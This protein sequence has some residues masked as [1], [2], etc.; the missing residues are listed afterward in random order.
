MFFRSKQAEPGH[1]SELNDVIRG[2]VPDADDATL[3]IVVAV[4]GLFGCISYA[5]SDF[6]EAE[7]D[8]VQRLLQS[9]HGIGPREARAIVTALHDNIV[10]IATVEAAR[11]YRALKEFGDR[12]L[13]VRVLEMLLEVAATDDSIEHSEVQFLRQATQSL[14]LEQ[15]DYNALQSK[16]K[17]KLAALKA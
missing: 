4:A 1:E 14:G 12:D 9:I 2:A 13:R 15:S 5:D 8:A 16:H 10:H 11:Y 17:D 6:S 7:S 3:R